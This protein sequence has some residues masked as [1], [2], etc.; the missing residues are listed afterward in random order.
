MVIPYRISAVAAAIC[1]I[2]FMAS[3]QIDKSLLQP[4]IDSINRHL[5]YRASVNV[6]ADIVSVD[7]YKNHIDIGFNKAVSDYPLRESDPDYITDIIRQYLPDA[8]RDYGINLL[9]CGKPMERLVLSHEK[10]IQARKGKMPRHSQ[11]VTAEEDR[12]EKGLSGRNIALWAGHGYYYSH[13]EDRWKWQ[14][15]PLF[16]TIEDLLPH[17]YVTEFL[18]PM[19]ENAGAYVVIPRERDTQTIE[20][21]VDNGD[22]FYS[23][24]NPSD[25]RENGWTDTPLP[26]FSRISGTYEAGCNPF[27][28]GSARMTENNRTSTASY[29][30]FFPEAGEYAVYVSYQSLPESV[31]AEYTVRYAG[32]EKKFKVDQRMGG[33]TWVYL[34]TFNFA[35]GETGQGVV[36]KGCESGEKGVITTDAVRFGGG[37]GIISRGAGTSGFPKYAEAARYWLQWCGFPESVYNPDKEDNDYKD[38]YMCRGEWVN[39]LK[40]ELGVPVDMAL[41][42]HTDAGSTLS[43]STVGTLAIYREESDGNIKYSDGNERITARK[44]SDIVQTSIV[45]DIRAAVRSDWTRRAIWDRSYV[46]ARVPDVPTVLIEMLSHQNFSDMRHALDPS[47]KFLV[48]RAI[49]KGILKYLAGR[50]ETPYTVQPLPVKDFSAS[51][52]SNKN[53]LAAV[54]LSWTPRHDSLEASAEPEYYILY[55][56]T[57]DTGAV[58]MPGFDKGTTVNDTSYIDYIEPGRLY[59]YQV[60]AVNDGGKSF[61]SETMSAGYVPGGKDVLIVNGFTDV[62]PPAVMPMCDSSYAG[63]DFTTDHGVP[64]MKDFSYIGEQYEFDRSKMWIHD[65]RPGFGASYMDFGPAP[66]AGNT[67]DYPAIHGMAMLRAGVSF[68]STSMS[69]FVDGSQLI[70]EF[71]AIDIIFGKQDGILLT[72]ALRHILHEYSSNGGALIISGANIGKSTTYDCDKLYTGDSVMMSVISRM[73]SSAIQLDRLAAFLAQ[74]GQDSLSE[75]IQHT[76][77]KIRSLKRE[78]IETIGCTITEPYRATDPEYIAHTTASDILKYRWSNG[79]ASTSGKVRSV[80]SPLNFAA[81]STITV[82]F[83]TEP[84]RSAYCVESPDAILPADDRAFTIM[85]YNTSNTSAAVAYDGD[86]R[87]VA[88]GFPIETL[89]SQHQ[90]DCLMCEVMKFLFRE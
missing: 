1:A 66:V 58:S 48:S 21:I 22:T 68:S 44:L 83:H 27:A 82:R 41:A 86:H 78:S 76:A 6:R 35:A 61:P 31:P 8:Y 79:S 64:Y 40:H 56:R 16:S 73:D 55:R 52:I 18:A 53:G 26:G 85:R 30:P 45:H 39:Y 23:E 38:D 36:V 9:Y 54:K 57:A 13:K 5:S 24:R 70:G 59:S 17:S 2:S 43:D 80:P 33:G 4:A 14:R 12:P 7:I 65:D 69:S 62:R 51:I 74:T 47:F 88:F 42:L 25:R 37:M 20:I 11:W 46:E 75:N 19:L 77:E 34:G 10:E 49:Y 67:F 89:T 72:P 63:F 3:A 15:A 60:V 32:G 29:L 28:S 81:D 87:S 50:S 84:C 90:I 71:D